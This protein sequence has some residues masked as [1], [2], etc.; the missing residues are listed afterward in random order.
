MLTGRLPIRSGIAGIHE[1]RRNFF[2][3]S[4]GGL[5]QR[6]ITIAEMLNL[7]LVALTC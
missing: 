3:T 4:S 2:P 5:P 6:V 7:F 1:E